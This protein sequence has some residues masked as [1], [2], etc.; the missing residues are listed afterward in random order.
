MR[1]KH[2][3]LGYVAVMGCAESGPRPP[4]GFD[5]EVR[6]GALHDDP[7][8]GVGKEAI[9]LDE[10]LRTAAP[11]R[12]AVAGIEAADLDAAVTT[13]D[14]GGA[15][16]T[17]MFAG[18]HI[19]GVPIHGAYLYLAM[20][21]G[22][23]G[24][25][26][27][28]GSSYHLYQ[29]ASIDTEP[30]VALADAVIA[31]RG[32]LRAEADVPV[33][34]AELAIWPLAGELTLVWDVVLEGAEARALV[35]ASG[36]RVGRVELEDDRRAETRG[37]VSG[38]I[39]V[40]GAPGGDGT[41]KLVPLAEATV[42]AGAATTITGGDGRYTL[43]AGAGA[44]IGAGA[45]G[46]AARVVSA[47]GAEVA[48]SAPAAA[49][50]DL[51]VGSAT[52]ER[53]LAVVT[54]FHTITR[55][56]AFLLANGFE[57]D[58]L[59][60]PVDARV[61]VT[62][63]CNAYYLPG[64]RRL[65]FLRAGGGC[66]NA[67]EATVVAHEYGH[68]VDD[69][70]GGIIDD[71]LSEGWGDLL[72]CL[73]TRQPVVGGDMFLDGSF[74]RTCDND[75]RYPRGGDDDPHDLGQAWAGFGWHL[76]AAL[77]AK[78]GA[79]AGDEL[80][81]GL[82]LPSLITN[83]PDIAAA[84]REVFLRDDDDGDLRNHTP[85]WELLLAAAERHGL[86]F[87]IEHD[88]APPA[89]IGDLRAASASATR[90]ELRWTAPGDDGRRG[91]AAAYDLRWS[92]A[93][94]TEA[95]FAAATRLPAP[96]PG[97][98]GSAQLTSIVVPPVGTAYV[99]LRARDERGNTG[100]LS[101]VLAVR[102]AAP[103]VIFR[104]GAEHGLGGWEAGGLWHV[105]THHAGEGVASFWYGLEASGSYDTGTR[106]RGALVSPV[107]DLAGVSG[108]VLVLSERID[109]EGDPTH[110]HLTITV[111]D[112]ED[113]DVAIAVPKA[114]GWTGAFRPRLIDLAGLSGRRIRVRF[115][116]DTVDR[117]GNAGQGW[118]VDD[119]EVIA[120][121]R[122]A[123]NPEPTTPPRLMINEILADP[124]AGYDADGDGT[125]GAVSDEFVELINAGTAA[126]DLSGGSISDGERIRGVFAPG[127]VVPAG[128]VL[129]VFG[130]G[131]P[132]LMGIHTVS[133]GPLQLNN[134]G[135][136]VT[137]RTA[138]GALLATAAFGSEGG[139]DQSLVRAVDG[140][141]A[142][143]FVLHQTRAAAVASPGRRASGQ[144]F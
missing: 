75:Y 47:D 25:G 143:G 109:V 94:I 15:P 34:T 81:R 64:Q 41:G 1:W 36:A 101:N 89:A 120:D 117:T 107:I 139:R 67:G 58:Q 48:A 23:D 33:R 98:A 135:D 93:P 63:S 57:A 134:G 130:G 43:A 27:L 21:P 62:G 44:M 16:L 26:E 99:A 46:R 126:L 113:P 118:S 123:P 73:S 131:V 144:P 78:L 97:P 20:R 110:D 92:T 108:P 35:V 124:P 30:A 133:F 31:A 90:I 61:N 84:V 22:G 52:A 49:K 9:A 2:V 14:A 56:R 74:I 51:T 45:S 40:G 125:A 6:G 29:G 132:R 79:T 96:R 54:A 12:E 95:G 83:A 28:V 140:D 106:N 87:A 24:G 32:A 127:T 18:Q 3:V 104:D 68:F 115:E 91:S 122:P 4:S 138:G 114:T 121:Q 66:R 137:V 37:T 10:V 119:I 69:S 72:A 8:R 105:T 65:E 70:F 116:V 129:V 42:S 77:I 59:G 19:D 112:A 39:A 136:T 88:L 86:G 141:P 7:V 13:T 76:R 82:L 71:G 60:G 11:L 142:A 103:A 38:W 5:R 17:T 128:G 80:A 53:S 102:L 55:T 85:H 50:V 100:P 111:V